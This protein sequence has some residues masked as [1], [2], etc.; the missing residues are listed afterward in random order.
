MTKLAKHEQPST[1]DHR[2]EYRTYY[3]DEWGVQVRRMGEHAP[4]VTST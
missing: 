4:K 1:C 3:G 2:E